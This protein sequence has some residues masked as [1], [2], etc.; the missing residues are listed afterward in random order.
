M[1]ITQKIP[2]GLEI[3]PLQKRK[4]KPHHPSVDN[5][6]LGGCSLD[7]FRSTNIYPPHLDLFRFSEND[8]RK[9]SRNNN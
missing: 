9:S 2:T 5:N 1:I 8:P 4:L 3:G 6:K 7:V